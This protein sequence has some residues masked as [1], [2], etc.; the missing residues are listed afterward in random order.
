MIRT[1][2]QVWQ[3]N[4]ALICGGFLLSLNSWY[5]D[6]KTPGLARFLPHPLQFIMHSNHTIRRS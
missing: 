2:D 3:V 1:G 4:V 5:G 6:T